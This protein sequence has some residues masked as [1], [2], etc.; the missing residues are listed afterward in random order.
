MEVDSSKGGGSLDGFTI[1][2][3]EDGETKGEVSVYEIVVDE[4]LVV[5]V[6]ITCGYTTYTV[7]G[8]VVFEKSCDDEE[9]EELD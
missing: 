4:D 7:E 8:T 9:E 1:D 2:D 6:D 3:T 5:T